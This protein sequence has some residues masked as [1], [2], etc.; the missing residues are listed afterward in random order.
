MVK[1]YPDWTVRQY[2]EHLLNEQDVYVSLK[3]ICE[4]LKKEGLTLKK[5]LTGQKK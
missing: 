1:N 4:F 3:G 2:R 5:K